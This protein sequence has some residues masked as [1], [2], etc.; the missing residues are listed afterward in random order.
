[1]CAPMKPDTLL[2]EFFQLREPNRTSFAESF[3]DENAEQQHTNSELLTEISPKISACLDG[4][5]I[6][7]YFDALE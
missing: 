4:T 3:R 1:M 6:R 2:Y 5:W 7:E